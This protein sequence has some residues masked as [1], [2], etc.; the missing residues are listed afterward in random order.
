MPPGLFFLVIVELSRRSKARR[1]PVK[2]RAP[3]P[4]GGVHVR[5]P[6]HQIRCSR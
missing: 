5:R 1:S 2:D 6:G 3:D 4:A